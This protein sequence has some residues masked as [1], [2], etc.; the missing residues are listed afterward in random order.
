MAWYLSLILLLIPLSSQCGAPIMHLVL[1]QRWLDCQ[2]KYTPAE[3]DAFL[4]GTL[5]PDIRYVTPLSREA[6]HKSGVTLEQVS[7][8]STSF[9]AGLLLHCYIDEW[10]AGLVRKWDAL[11]LV[12]KAPRADTLLKLVEDELLYAEY[13]ER[14]F[15]P[16]LHYEKD[17]LAAGIDREDVVKWHTLLAKYL[18]QRPSQI[19]AQFKRARRSI[20]DVDAETVAIWSEEVPLLAKKPEAQEYVDRILSEFERECDASKE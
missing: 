1:A 7:E 16:L 19:L 8:A 12:G 5:Y 13:R 9:L 11:E 20:F 10:R 18:S 4:V 2:D 17:E 14:P 3:R 15:S 6:T